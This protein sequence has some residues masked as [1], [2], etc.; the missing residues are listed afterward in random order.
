[1]I[2]TPVP[3]ILQIELGEMR[4]HLLAWLARHRGVYPVK[5][6]P[7]LK[8]PDRQYQ[9]HHDIIFLRDSADMDL[10]SKLIYFANIEM[11]ELTR[12]RRVAV[13]ADFD[14]KCGFH[15]GQLLTLSFDGLCDDL[16]Y[17]DCFEEL[18]VVIGIFKHG[19]LVSISSVPKGDHSAYSIESLHEGD[20]EGRS[21]RVKGEILGLD[22]DVRPLLA[23][24]VRD[25]KI[26]ACKLVPRPQ[27]L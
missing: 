22:K 1:M 9:P 11:N 21:D 5:D 12:I 19:K 8:F 20:L 10:F 26:T 7:V 18:F 17:L 16:E 13:A 2:K 4:S 15:I 6:S 27:I 24:H 14:C 3:P 25:A 23:E